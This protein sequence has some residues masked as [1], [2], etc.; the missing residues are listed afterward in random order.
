MKIIGITGRMGSGKTTLARKISEE[1]DIPIFDCDSH[2]KSAYKD[3]L[4]ID[5]LKYM[6][7]PDL[8][9][10]DKVDLQEIAKFIF[11][12]RNAEENRRFIQYLTRPFVI[13]RLRDS[14]E[15]YCNV[16]ERKALIVECAN[17]EF[18][19]NILVDYIFVRTTG[20]DE[21]NRKRCFERANKYGA[22]V[23]EEN[24]ERILAVQ[25]SEHQMLKHFQ[26]HKCWEVT[27]NPN[28]TESV[29]NILRKALNE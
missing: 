10:D 11:F 20:N 9:Q 19:D 25:A 27:D 5:I 4:I 21:I 22:Y 26:H 7:Y 6:P 1:L 17:P 28:S 24:V 8:V 13:N 3:K 12:Y 2:A 18:F 16:E 29:I 23:L 14:M 15:F